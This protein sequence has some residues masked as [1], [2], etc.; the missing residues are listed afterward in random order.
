ME[1][2]NFKKIAVI[3]MGFLI[4]EALSFLVF[5]RP[6]LNGVLLAILSLAVIIISAYRLEYGFLALLGELFIGSMGHLFFINLTEGQLPLRMAI[7]S[8]F[9]AVFAVKFVRQLIIAGKMK[10]KPEVEDAE[11]AEK[12]EENSYLKNLKNFGGAKFFII[13]AF[14][15]VL[16]L[17]NGFARGHAGNLIFS[18]FNSW[19]FFLLIIPA[20]AIYGGGEEEKIARLKTCFLAGALWLSLKTLILL[21]IFTHDSAISQ[22]VYTWLRKTLSGEMTPTKADWPRVFIQ[23]QIYS[24][25]AFFASFWAS[26]ASFKLKNI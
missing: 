26:Q 14:F 12:D 24:G 4:I 8:A 9:M 5:S 10:V 11:K 16:A 21:F 22:E 23:G 7:W 1:K 20:A 6:L 19:L 3:M 25:I 17:I 13:L 18:D 2:I 15:V